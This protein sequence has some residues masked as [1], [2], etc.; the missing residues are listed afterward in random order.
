[1]KFQFRLTINFVAY[2]RITT[3]AAGLHEGVR[4]A[5][6]TGSNPG[7]GTGQNGQ[8]RRTP[9]QVLTP[10]LVSTPTWQ[11]CTG[12]HITKP[13]PGYLQAL[14]SRSVAEQV[15]TDKEMR[16]SAQNN[17]ANVCV[18]FQMLPGYEA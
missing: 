11:P 14:N 16:N 4:S 17:A 7:S 5:V 2:R 6:F 15:S 10:I 9:T 3:L 18:C 8:F 13:G 12:L 1:M